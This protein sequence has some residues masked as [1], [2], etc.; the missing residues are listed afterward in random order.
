MLKFLANEEL[1]HLKILLD[2][3]TA[4][5]KSGTWIDLEKHRTV[6]MPNVYSG[7][8]SPTSIREDSEDADIVLEAIRAE[9][10]TEDF[11]CRIRDKLPDEKGKAFFNMMSKFERGHYALLRSLLP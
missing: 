10:R 2:L 6:R 5:Q 3:K 7:M 8:E 1:N 9:K 11:Y 4:L